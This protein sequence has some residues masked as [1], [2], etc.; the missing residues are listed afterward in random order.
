MRFGW[1]LLGL[2]LPGFAAAE[3]L[4]VVADSEAKRWLDSEVVSLSLTAGDVV[5]VVYRIDGMVRVRKGSDFGWVRE[6]RLKAR[7]IELI[8]PE[9][10]PPIE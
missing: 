6:D 5:Q 2:L 7:A 4:E 10:L 3:D 9:A 8:P 1:L